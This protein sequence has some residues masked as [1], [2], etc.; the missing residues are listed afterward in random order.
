MTTFMAASS[1]RMRSLS[2]QFL[3]ARASL[4]AA[5]SASIFATSTP[6]F[7]PFLA[8]SSRGSSS[9]KPKI[10]SKSATRAAF[11][12]SSIS[13]LSIVFM[14]PRARGMFRSSPM[15]SL[16]SCWKVLA[17]SLSIAVAL[18]IS[19]SVFLCKLLRPSLAPSRASHV[20][21]R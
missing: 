9:F 15:A 19:G 7:A 13:L 8:Y 1:S 6:S 12:P 17:A 5:I 11:S 3:V 4:R 18:P 14:I 10:W 2:A 20:K 21:F 16:N